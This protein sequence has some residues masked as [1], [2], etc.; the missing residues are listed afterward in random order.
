MKVKHPFFQILYFVLAA[1]S[2]VLLLLLSLDIIGRGILPLTIAA[3]LFIAG[4]V[5]LYILLRLRHVHT[6][7]TLERDRQL[8]QNGPV[9][10]CRWDADNQR[11]VSFMSQ[12][13]SRFGYDYSDFTS[14]ALFF[15]DLIHPED[16][17]RI[18]SATEG[19]GAPGRDY[20]EDDFRLR[21]RNGDYVWVMT[22]VHLVKNSEGTPLFYDAFFLDIDDRKKLEENEHRHNEELE[23]INRELSLLAE[24]NQRQDWLKTGLSELN[25]H[26]QGHEHLQ[27]LF[28]VIVADIVTYAEGSLGVLYV[29]DDNRLL[30]PAACFGCSKEELSDTS[31]EPGEGLPGQTGRER[32][33]HVLEDI[34][35]HHLR[36]RTGFGDI[37][38]H[39]VYCVPLVFEG[40]LLGVLEI[41]SLEP[42][43]ELKRLFIR[44]G[45]EAASAAVHFGEIRKHQKELLLQTQR[46]ARRLQSQQV[47]LQKT[48]NALQQSETE[49]EE[50]KE[51]LKQLNEELQMQQEEL[52][53]TNEEL[54]EKARM[55]TDQRDSIKQQK[56]D[57]ERVSRELE[58]TSRYKS[59]FLANMS[60]ELR[61]P[62][63][64]MLIL[65]QV[66]GAN[67]EGNLSDKQVQAAQTIQKAGNELL[68]LI[69]DILDI[70]KVESGKLSIHPEP[71]DA[72]ELVSRLE[73]KIEPHAESKGLRFTVSLSD[74]LAAADIV[75]DTQ[76]VEQI[77]NN[78]L[79]NAVKFTEEGEITL[80]GDLW[81]PGGEKGSYAVFTVT[82]T[83]R[84][85]PEDE[86]A[87]V[88][89]A[90]HQV[91]GPANR[92][93]EG[94]GLGLSISR[95]LAELLGGE[96]YIDSSSDDGTVFVLR[97]PFRLPA[98]FES[99]SGRRPGGNIDGTEAESPRT[100]DTQGASSG[101]TDSEP[102]A[103]RAGKTLLV[104]E[105]DPVFSKH[106]IEMAE[107]RGFSCFHASDAAEGIELAS[108]KPDAII[109][110]IRL[111][112]EDG[113]VVMEM[114]KENPDTRHIP[115]HFI[116][117]GDTVMDAMRMGAIGYLQKPVS[118][119]GLKKAF[120]RIEKFI[121]KSK[122]CLL[123]VEDDDRLR[124]SILE[125]LD[126]RDVTTEG[127][128]T[129]REALEKLKHGKCD[130]M[131]LDIGLPD[132]DGFEL[133]EEIR[134]DSTISQV[135]II[136][137]TGKDLSAEEEEI[138]HRYA[139]SIIIKS[140][141]SPERLLDETALFLH[142]IESNLPGDKQQMIRSV[143]DR[144]SFWN[145]KKVLVADDDMRNVFALTIFLEEK[146]I[147]TF[148]A[149]N[150][151]EC[152]EILE[153]EEGIDLVLMDI[154]MPEMDGYEAIEEI[155][156]RER[157][158]NLPVIALTAK[159]MKGDRQKCIDAGANDYLTKPVDGAKLLSMMRVWL[160]E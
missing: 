65:S 54:E 126:G 71:L 74:E 44:R 122:R 110:D 94:T 113:F 15:P 132:M 82:D 66:L 13:I 4:T 22:R 20:F 88:F 81:A 99:S 33:P 101:Q 10:V 93:D 86:R 64:S 127:A 42:I 148:E 150:G 55:L 3:V 160:H 48:N 137:Y 49:L 83:G 29:P 100:S 140:A 117:A 143:H 36:Y 115:V 6:D 60:H 112:D 90:F 89:E 152:I 109:L 119:E 2:I 28:D 106:L 63:N 108:S 135:P 121:T 73:A 25:K 91:E 7:E 11:S 80:T 53:V 85:I 39:T 133:L 138:L 116:S 30:L 40:E 31:F 156:K 125:L 57:L 41:G 47:E 153:E 79:S 43:T 102:P 5:T 70:A 146:G 18:I 14:G 105:D 35:E 136:I 12:N 76:R 51:E 59:D 67:E 149:K 155:R 123:V 52:R 50:Q 58:R 87:R 19:I 17:D 151:R 158:R 131:V 129:G 23:Q 103:R 96:L 147:K 16:R 154:M 128:S 98:G 56:D 38:P 84:G 77:L 61:T 142:R 69:N 8:F 46:Q 26:L 68:T 114:L 144:D 1:S 111:P 157:F 107:A 141:K 24:E 104:I 45:A 92:H 32:K 139:E 159:A 21:M 37:F 145:G 9:V 118:P 120:N 72:G 97:I 62:L 75:T 27:D 130:C 78:L 34:G 95:E 124:G 134:R